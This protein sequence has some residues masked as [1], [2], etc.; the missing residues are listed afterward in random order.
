MDGLTQ[1]RRKFI[2][3]ETALIYL[4]ILLSTVRSKFDNGLFTF[5]SFFTQ[6]ITVEASSKPI[7]SDKIRQNKKRKEN[8]NDTKNKQICS[9]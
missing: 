4:K 5:F 1:Q 6:G 9:E 7:C 3:K 8:M 2:I